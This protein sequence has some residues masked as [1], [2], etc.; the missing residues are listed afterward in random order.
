[1]NIRYSLPVPA[2][3]PYPTCHRSVQHLEFL[4][5]LTQNNRRDWFKAN[6]SRYETG[7]GPLRGTGGQLDSHW[8]NRTDAERHCQ[9]SWWFCDA[10]LQIPF[11]K[12][13]NTL[14][15][16]CRNF[17]RHDADGTIHARRLSA[18][19]Y[20]NFLG[21]GCWRPERTATA[22]RDAIAE[23]PGGTGQFDRN[24]L[25]LITICQVIPQT[26]PRG[27]PD[28]PKSRICVASIHRCF[29]SARGDLF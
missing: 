22:I 20:S 28:H 9:T 21:V 11:F 25:A 27:S 10:D 19:G 17:L 13:Q 18:S 2:P 4:S 5:E 7:A 24:A 23:D 16:E 26:A 15:D 6:K 12:R 8:K 1:M 14:Q 3:L 29:L